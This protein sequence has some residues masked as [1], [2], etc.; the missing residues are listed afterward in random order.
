MSQAALFTQSGAGHLPGS[1]SRAGPGGGGRGRHWAFCAQLPTRPGPETRSHPGPR[2]HA[3]LLG[4]E[5][6]QDGV[7]SPAS[8]LAPQ[9]SG[10][11][12]LGQSLLALGL[13]SSSPKRGIENWTQ[14]WV[15]WGIREGEGKKNSGPEGVTVPRGDRAGAATSLLGGNM[16]PPWIG[17]DHLLALTY[18]PNLQHTSRHHLEHLCTPGHS[19]VCEYTDID[20]PLNTDTHLITD[21]HISTNAC[22]RHLHQHGH[23]HRHTTPRTHPLPHT[24]HTS[25]HTSQPPTPIT[26]HT[27]SNSCGGHWGAE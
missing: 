19:S 3:A 13:V 8:T 4:E 6:I 26:Y 9:L 1:W 16:V 27:G 23:S 17:P 12:S 15:E 5:R 7:G 25:M 18:F 14:V 11:V 21:T 10:I 22:S 2:A 20:T 24:H